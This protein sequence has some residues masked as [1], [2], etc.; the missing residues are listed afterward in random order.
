[1]Y[2]PQQQKTQQPKSTKKKKL[3]IQWPDWIS[4]EKEERF[5]SPLGLANRDAEEVE[6]EEEKRRC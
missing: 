2:N 1:M 6:V 5:L 3:S 4:T